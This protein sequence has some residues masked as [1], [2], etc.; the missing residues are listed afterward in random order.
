[1]VRI[2]VIE[3]N[4]VLRKLIQRMLNEAGHEV[5]LAS[6]SSNGLGLWQAHEVELV[7][8]DVGLPG[9]SGVETIIDMRTLEPSLPI[10]VISGREEEELID[11]TTGAGLMSGVG[12]L[13]K[14]FQLDELV[15]A[16]EVALVSGDDTA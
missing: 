15:A 9:R 10:I 13:T 8:V 3:D 1:V 4:E 7:V 2:L 11:L 16:V 12:I 6:E 5:I 14:P